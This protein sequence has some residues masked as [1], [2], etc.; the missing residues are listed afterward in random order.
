MKKPSPLS[1]SVS[2]AHPTLFMASRPN[3]CE[4]AP[5]QPRGEIE[6][7]NLQNAPNKY[8]SPLPLLMQISPGYAQMPLCRLQST[9]SLGLLCAFWA[10][11]RATKHTAHSAALR[12]WFP[13]PRT[14]SVVRDWEV[15]LCEEDGLGISASC[16]EYVN[17]SFATYSLCGVGQVT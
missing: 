1:Q 4:I 9:E 8:P 10:L 7:W 2:L 15:L 13:W 11:N 12:D 16:K 17:P 6:L 5:S 3:P 14:Y